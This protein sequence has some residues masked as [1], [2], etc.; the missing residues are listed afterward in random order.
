M[1]VPVDYNVVDHRFYLHPFFAG[2]YTFSV[3]AADNLLALWVGPNAVSGFSINN[4][5]F[6][7]ESANQP[8]P[9]FRYTAGPGDV[10]SFIP[11]R[12]LWANNGG[13]GALGV[14]VTDPNGV[15]ILGAATD[16]ND[17]IVWRC[18]NSGGAAPI[19]PDWE[20][21]NAA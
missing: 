17:Q 19:W 1:D 21:E 18:V 13:R 15:E 6:K 8:W 16:V 12:V 10:G 5:A 4:V 20:T 11:V 3:T 14:S 7:W 9:S 2:T